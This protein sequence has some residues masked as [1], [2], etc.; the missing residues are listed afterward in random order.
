MPRALQIAGSIVAPTTLL[1]GLFVYFGLMYVV[2]YYRYFGVN[3]S[4]LNVTVQGYLILSVSTAVL[5]LG[6]LAGAVL[7]SLRVYLLPLDEVSGT[8]RRLLHRVPYPFVGIA[9]VVLVGLAVAD[10]LTVFRPF[11]AAMTEARGLSLSVGVLLLG[12]AGRLRRDVGPRRGHRTAPREVPVI[13]TVV[14][15]GGFCL[16]LGIGLFWAVGS[17]AVRMGQADARAF[18]LNLACTPDV[19]LYSEAR[20]NLASSG[21]EEERATAGEGEAPAAEGFAFRYTGLKL[22]PQVGDNY[23]LLPADWAP[24]ARPAILLTRSDAIRLEFAPSPVC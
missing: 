3:F 15:W 22:V 17:Y 8:V 6:V 20:L 10:A 14:K 11:P 13:L 9:G 2:A 7:L 23:L 4:V 19:V 21:V 5:P 16:L 18:A 24:A 1:T 12:Y